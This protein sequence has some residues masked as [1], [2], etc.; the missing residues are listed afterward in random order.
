LVHERGQLASVEEL[1]QQIDQF[2]FVF[3]GVSRSDCRPGRLG[4][5]RRLAIRLPRLRG[6]G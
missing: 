6:P 5:R 2:F 3:H 4:A 1:E